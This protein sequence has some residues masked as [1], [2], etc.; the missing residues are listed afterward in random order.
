MSQQASGIIV[1]V[2]TY[3]SKEDIGACLQAVQ[4]CPV[5]VT[6]NTVVVDNASTDGTAEIV[7]REFPEVQLIRNDKNQYYAAANNQGAAIGAE[8]YILLL[9]P[10]V[11]LGENTLY[12]L[13]DYLKRNPEVAAVAPKLFFPDGRVQHSVRRFPTYS[14]LWLEISGL[15]RLFPRRAKTSGWRMDLQQVNSPL[16]VDQPMASCFLVRRSVWESLQGFDERFPMFFN[17]VDFCYR[18]KTSGGRIVYLPKVTALHRGGAST[19][20]VKTRMIWFSHLGFLRFLRKHHR[21]PIDLFKYVLAI[22]LVV[23]VAA[24]RSLIWIFR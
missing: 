19:R 3:N 1:V 9:N 23:L 21:G 12:E 7:A 16:E 17:D 2:V 20:S 18:L 10:D 11:Q 8:E 15:C 22:P 5:G 24:L 13:V 6:V 14:I 4:G